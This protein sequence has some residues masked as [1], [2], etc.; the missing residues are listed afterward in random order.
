MNDTCPIGQIDFT[1][2][3]SGCYPLGNKRTRLRILGYK[4]PNSGAQ[5]VDT[6][7]LRERYQ[8]SSEGRLVH[9]S[10][11]RP[12]HNVTWLMNRSLDAVY[13][14][15]HLDDYLMYSLFKALNADH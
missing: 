11:V 2:A 9:E 1:V 10:G 13:T 12:Y 14:G 8:H 6:V 5:I 3:S 4:H 15:L 7:T